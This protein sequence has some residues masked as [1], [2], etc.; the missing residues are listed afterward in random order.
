MASTT[1]TS[2]TGSEETTKVEIDDGVYTAL[3]SFIAAI[4]I[5]AIS[6]L[7]IAGCQIAI[8]VYSRPK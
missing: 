1:T 8:A 3:Y 6:L 5:M 4:G 7:I 2:G